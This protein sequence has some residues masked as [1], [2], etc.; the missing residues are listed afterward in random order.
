LG[1]DS[2]R[3]LEANMMVTQDIKICC[4]EPIRGKELLDRMMR[5]LNYAGIPE[6]DNGD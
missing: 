4:S 3:G 2:M 6:I 5:K 1:H